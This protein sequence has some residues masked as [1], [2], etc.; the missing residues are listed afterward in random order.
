M[1]SEPSAL[2]ERNQSI[3]NLH[4][5]EKNLP[6]RNSE[7]TVTAQEPE[8]VN[9]NKL[10]GEPNG[11]YGWVN[12][13]CCFAINAHTW[14]VRSSFLLFYIQGDLTDSAIYLDKLVLW[15]VPS[16]LFEQQLLPGSNC[17]ALCFCRWSVHL[18][19]SLSLANSN[20]HYSV[21]RY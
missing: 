17:S 14:G 12:V 9:N 11:G 13:A 18:S 15:S 19:S 6:R 4:V 7:K 3:D 5:A 8:A 2:Q 21:V 16:L 1:S 10:P 20:Y